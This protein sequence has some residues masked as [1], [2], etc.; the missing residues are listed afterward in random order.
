MPNVYHILKKIVY[1][2]ICQNWKCVAPISALYFYW[3][4][5]RFLPQTLIFSPFFLIAS[6]LYYIF[7]Q[8]HN[9]SNL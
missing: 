4:S 5:V 7:H 2:N 9:R 6:V 8:D 1:Y 3:L